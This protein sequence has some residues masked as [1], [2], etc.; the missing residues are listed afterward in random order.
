MPKVISSQDVLERL[1][2][3]SKQRKQLRAEIFEKRRNGENVDE[4]VK[5]RIRLKKNVY[6]LKHRD[7][8]KTKPHRVAQWKNKQI[9]LYEARIAALK[10][11]PPGFKICDSKTAAQKLLMLEEKLAS[12]LHK[13]TALE[14]ENAAKE[15]E[16]IDHQIKLE[17]KELEEMNKQS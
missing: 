6:Y 13:C 11:L 2:E 5:Q 9:S 14:V 1:F 7:S 8:M 15:I 3:L 10:Q 16:L 12:I 4:L 17:T